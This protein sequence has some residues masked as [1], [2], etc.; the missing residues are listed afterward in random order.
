MIS[1]NIDLL[2]ILDS[3]KL[4]LNLDLWFCF[5]HFTEKFISF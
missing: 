4:V 2:Q 3:Q 1:E 5:E